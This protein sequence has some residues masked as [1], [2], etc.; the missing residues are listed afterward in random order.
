MADEFVGRFNSATAHGIAPLAGEAIVQALL[1]PLEIADQL[2]NRLGRLGIRR[3]HPLQPPDDP[4]HFSVKQPG[5][6]GL[7][8]FSLPF[9][10]RP[11]LQRG[12]LVGFQAATVRK[13]TVAL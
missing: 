4:V 6:G 3:L 11:V 8:P 2:G 7:T 9:G 10:L 1:M 5:Q 12:D 13:P